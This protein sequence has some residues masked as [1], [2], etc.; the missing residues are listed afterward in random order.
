[1]KQKKSSVAAVAVICAYLI[2]PLALTFLYS[3]F[4]RWDDILLSGFTMQ[5][6]AQAF[7]DSRFLAA[8]GRTLLIS[9]L[10][11]VVCKYHMKSTEQM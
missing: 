4:Q 10:P 6:F 7:S 3:V 8:L 1:M 11:I 5:Y 9:I 2:L